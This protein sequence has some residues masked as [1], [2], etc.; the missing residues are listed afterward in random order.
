MNL[1]AMKPLKPASI[2]T[3]NQQILPTFRPTPFQ[4]DVLM[5][6]WR[7]S[8]PVLYSLLTDLAPALAFFL[9]LP[10]ALAITLTLGL[11]LILLVPAPGLCLFLLRSV[12]R[13]IP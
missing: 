6:G 5:N 4:S 1:T 10:L 2:T 12:T 13:L 7:N 11:S 8:P 3:S 9:A